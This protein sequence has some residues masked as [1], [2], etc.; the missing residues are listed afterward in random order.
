MDIIPTN[1]I[2]SAFENPLDEWKVEEYTLVMDELMLSH[3]FPP[4]RGYYSKIDEGDA[5]NPD[6]Y[7]MTDEKVNETHIGEI[8]WMV[9]D[10]HHR[11][12]AAIKAHLP[13][14]CTELDQSTSSVPI[15][16]Y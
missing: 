13:H 7:F 8:V 9:T 12:S 1:R 3:D 6:L 14:L 10:G 2:I 4:I 16:E 15:S 11:T 5:E